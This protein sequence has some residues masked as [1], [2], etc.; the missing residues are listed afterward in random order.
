MVL[1]E[2]CQNLHSHCLCSNIKQL[3]A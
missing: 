1:T 2:V 3:A